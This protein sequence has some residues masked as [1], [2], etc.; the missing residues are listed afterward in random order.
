MNE[1]AVRVFIE[2]F[3]QT[4]GIKV[5]PSFSVLDVYAIIGYQLNNRKLFLPPNRKYGLYIEE[6]RCWMAGDLELTYFPSVKT[7]NLT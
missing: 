3:Q 1:F 6:S 2:D 4:I 5:L 7:V